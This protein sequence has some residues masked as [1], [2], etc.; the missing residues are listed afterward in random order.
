MQYIAII[1]FPHLRYNYNI[2][3]TIAQD[4][5][6][7]A[8]VAQELT[9]EKY[10]LRQYLLFNTSCIYILLHY[11]LEQVIMSWFDDIGDSDGDEQVKE[12]KDDGVDEVMQLFN[13]VKIKQRKQP[14][15]SSFLR[16]IAL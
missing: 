15:S 11:L 10:F 5:M 8:C 9:R 6:L 4:L 2:N 16:Y 3:T 13:E 12:E 14:A 1:S 7:L